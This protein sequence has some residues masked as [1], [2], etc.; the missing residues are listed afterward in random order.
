MSSSDLFNKPIR[1]PNVVSKHIRITHVLIVYKKAVNKNDGRKIVII[2]GGV[3]GLGFA[4]H[5]AKLGVMDV[6]LIEGHQL[7]SGTSWHAAG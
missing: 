7:T 5:L 2:C 3:I 6:L 1:C 4:Y